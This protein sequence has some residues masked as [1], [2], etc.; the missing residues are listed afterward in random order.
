M[1]GKSSVSGRR[2]MA[3]VEHLKTS[4]MMVAAPLSAARAGVKAKLQQVKCH[5]QDKLGARSSLISTTYMQQSAAMRHGSALQQSNEVAAIAVLV[6]DRLLASQPGEHAA[7][8]LHAGM[9]LDGL[10]QGAKYSG[11]DDK[12]K[13]CLR[14]ARDLCDTQDDS[15][16]DAQSSSGSVSNEI[17]MNSCMATAQLMA[18]LVKQCSNAE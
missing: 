14:I 6:R 13:T 11:Y 8:L 17:V 5:I 2:F 4:K 16:D 9:R 1:S 10:L 15:Q 18:Q 12:T 7:A 3:A